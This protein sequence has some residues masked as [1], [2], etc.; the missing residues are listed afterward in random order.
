MLVKTFVLALAY[1]LVLLQKALKLTFLLI[2]LLNIYILSYLS[3]VRNPDPL[4]GMILFS[5]LSRFSGHFGADGPSPLDRDTTVFT[6][7]KPT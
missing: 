1:I 6:T 7:K 5:G 3:S 4:N 2:L